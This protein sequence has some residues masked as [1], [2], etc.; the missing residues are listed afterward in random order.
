VCCAVAMWGGCVR[1]A[2]AAGL[3]LQP[4][5]LLPPPA[6]P[7]PIARPLAASATRRRDRIPGID[8]EVGDGDVFKLGET[9]WRVGR[10]CAALQLLL[11]PGLR[12]AGWCLLH[13]G[14]GSGLWRLPAGALC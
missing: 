14:G 2:G 5:A 9:E 4:A 12:A 10:R 1:R 3:L 7:L 6:A 13:R 11:A 8:V